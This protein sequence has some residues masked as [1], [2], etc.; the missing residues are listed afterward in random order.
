[1]KDTEIYN[2]WVTVYREMITWDAIVKYQIG[3]PISEMTRAGNALKLAYLKGMEFALG[4]ILGYPSTRGIMCFSQLINTL[5]DTVRI[6]ILDEEFSKNG[7]RLLK[8]HDRKV[9]RTFS[10]I[11]KDGKSVLKII[12]EGKNNEE[13]QKN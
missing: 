8:L 1:M 12:L 3:K 2:R 5:D 10:Y 7:V 11:T 9:K 4:E 6:E 13:V